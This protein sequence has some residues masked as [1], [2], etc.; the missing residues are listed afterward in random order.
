MCPIREREREWERRPACYTCDGSHDIPGRLHGSKKR[1]PTGVGYCSSVQP[2]CVGQTPGST[3][4]CNNTYS[5]FFAIFQHNNGVLTTRPVGFGD[6]HAG[7]NRENSSFCLNNGLS[8]LK[9]F[10][11]RK[12]EKRITIPASS[13]GSVWP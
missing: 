6:G 13:V 11:E 8:L 9:G 4:L 5:F 1:P 10:F 7:E 2:G 3:L 12:G